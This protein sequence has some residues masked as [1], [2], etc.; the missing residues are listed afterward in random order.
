MKTRL[1]Y[2]IVLVYVILYTYFNYFIITGNMCIGMLKMEVKIMTCHVKY[3]IDKNP[4]AFSFVN[5]VL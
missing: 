2:N 1:N 3:G 5:H 4:L